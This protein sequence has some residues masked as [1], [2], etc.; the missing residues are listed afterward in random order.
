[1]AS[2]KQGGKG[3]KDRKHSREQSKQV[4]LKPQKTARLANEAIELSRAG[5]PAKALPLLRSAAERDPKHPGIQFNLAIVCNLLG[6]YD[7]ALMA[8]RTTLRIN[9]GSAGQ[10]VKLAQEQ[11]AYGRLTAAR[12]CYSALVDAA[13]GAADPLCLRALTSLELGDDPAAENDFAAAVTADAKCYAAWYGLARFRPLPEGTV[14]PLQAALTAIKPSRHAAFAL[15]WHYHHTGEADRAFACFGEANRI[16]IPQMH[17]SPQQ[18]AADLNGHAGLLRG[19]F[20]TEYFHARAGW[21]R[22]EV[23]PVFVLGMPL[24]GQNSFGRAMAALDP[25][26]AVWAG[27]SPWFNQ[28]IFQLLGTHGQDF[29][30]VVD[31]VDEKTAHELADSYLLAHQRTGR[32]IL[33]T[34]PYN[35]LNLWLI[36]LLFPQAL[37]IDCRRARNENLLA[38]FFSDT[39]TQPYTADLSAIAS[40]YEGCCKL[41]EFWDSI[42]PGWIV[43]YQ[44]GDAIGALAQRAG[45]V[46]DGTAHEKKPLASV[47]ECCALDSTKA[48]PYST[49]VPATALAGSLGVN[50]D[51]SAPQSGGLNLN[52]GNPASA[53]AAGGLTLNFGQPSASPASSD[54]A[55]GPATKF[56]LEF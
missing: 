14:E 11:T 20:S 28:R 12:T 42:L 15:G 30:K 41:M 56:K 3:G 50:L 23:K 18:A 25:Q 26:S 45:I 54:P 27:E 47:A 2:K 44:Y 51:F 37:V 32:I 29:Q 39:P 6:L 22:P 17:V 8:L 31:G 13:P 21:G 9:P 7:E 34:N 33:D 53:P 52:F 10:V 49:Q 16:A 4:T 48:E 24:A 19:L 36:R 1:M 40:Y 55:G 43:P 35:F 38:C 46:T 5:D